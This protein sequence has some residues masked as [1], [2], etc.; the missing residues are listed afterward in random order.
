VVSSALLELV[1]LSCCRTVCHSQLLEVM[2]LSSLR[3]RRS[4]EEYIHGALLKV[5]DILYIVV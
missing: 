1:E 3:V 4:E 5:S 2:Q